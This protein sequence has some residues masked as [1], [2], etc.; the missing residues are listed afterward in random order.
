MCSLDAKY[1]PHLAVMLKSLLASNPGQAIRAHVLQDGIAPELRQRVE[2]CTKPISIRWLNVENH[3]ILQLREK[4]RE[5]GRGAGHVTLATL[6]RL[7]MVELL[8]PSIKRVLYLDVDLVVI[9][10]LKELWHLDLG[11]KLCAAVADP[12][13]DT[14][15][16]VRKWGLTGG[17]QY[18]NAG[19]MLLDLDKLRGKSYF[20]RAIE[21][22]ARGD[23]RLVFSDQDALNLVLW[24]EWLPIDPGWNFQRG[25]LLSERPPWP[26]L[27]PYKREPVIIHFTESEKP[28]R[29]SYRHPCAWLY[30][31]TLLRTNFRKEVLQAGQINI[32]LLVKAWLRWL[33]KRPPIFRCAS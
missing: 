24:N 13:I 22:L 2:A 15:E 33:I 3:H 30:L 27:A 19:V 31:R 4:M 10:D 17:G 8:D 11:D 9:G 23:D 14:K 16:F 7:L 28:W 18:F 1:V 5:I 12:G 6:L 32:T 21:I 26:G 29:K 20:A 25:F